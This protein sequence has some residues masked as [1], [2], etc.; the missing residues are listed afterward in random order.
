M[1]SIFAAL[2]LFVLIATPTLGAKPVDNP[3]T[4]TFT[5]SCDPAAAYQAQDIAQYRGDLT[6]PQDMDF[7]V[8][9]DRPDD[10]RAI[11]FGDRRDDYVLTVTLPDG[12]TREARYSVGRI[13]GSGSG[14]NAIVCV[15]AA[16]VG[17]Y[18]VHLDGT[19]T[20]L[21]LSIVAGGFYDPCP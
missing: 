4:Q 3:W 20:D 21:S 18:T 15:D 13:T 9:C 16:P 6:E 11:V 5:Q 1:R 19:G 10:F 14:K 2:F 8:N 12:S 17:T 7:V